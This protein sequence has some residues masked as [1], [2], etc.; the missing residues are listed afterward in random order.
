MIGSIIL[1]E[2][3]LS[4]LGIGVARPYPLYVYLFADGQSYF[5][6][7]WWIAT[8]PA[9]AIA[10]FVMGINILG[11]DCGKCGKWSNAYG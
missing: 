2:A 10:I 6:E 4:Y 3:G 5:S 1:E 9:L 7:G 8:F 11:T